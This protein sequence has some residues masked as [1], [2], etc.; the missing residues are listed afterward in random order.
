MA[1][2]GSLDEATKLENTLASFGLQVNVV[3]AQVGPAVTLYELEVPVGVRLNKVVT[4]SNEIAAS[5]RAESVRVI[6]PIPGKHTVGVEVPNSQRR[7][8][9]MR[10][11]ISKEIYEKK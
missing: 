6:A 3:H 7:V 1:Q 9:R 8:V 11:L 2:G 4:L 5:L 10:E